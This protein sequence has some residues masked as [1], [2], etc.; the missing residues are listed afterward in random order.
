M[1]IRNN[2]I[3]H[4]HRML[5]EVSANAICLIDPKSDLSGP[6][7]GNLENQQSSNECH[8]QMLKCEHNFPHVNSKFEWQKMARHA[9]KINKNR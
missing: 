2:H 9:Q 8:K 5:M 3:T 4:T 6:K 1:R 7:R